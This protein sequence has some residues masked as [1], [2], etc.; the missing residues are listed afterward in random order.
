MAVEPFCVG[1][2]G[3]DKKRLVLWSVQITLHE[4]VDSSVAGRIG[5]GVKRM[6]YWSLTN[7]LHKT[8]GQWLAE[9]KFDFIQ[10]RDLAA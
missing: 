1:R 3:G 7:T 10:R 4:A 9:S 2:I 5:G 8:A 6:M